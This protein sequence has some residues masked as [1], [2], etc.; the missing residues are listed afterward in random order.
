MFII[1]NGDIMCDLGPPVIWLDGDNGTGFWRV[2]KVC[3]NVRG[4]YNYGGL[5]GL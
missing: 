4:L 5:V 2:N 1:R 3:K